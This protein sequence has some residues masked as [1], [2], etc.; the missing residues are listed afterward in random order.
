MSKTGAKRKQDL[1]EE[2]SNEEILEMDKDSF[3]LYLRQFH[4]FDEETLQRIQTQHIDAHALK[5][6]G[7]R[8]DVYINAGFK[9]G[10]VSKLLRLGKELEQTFNGVQ[11]LKKGKYI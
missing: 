4:E 8:V 11:K 3:V 1:T 7:D 10:P 6:L 5:D 2:P 9:I